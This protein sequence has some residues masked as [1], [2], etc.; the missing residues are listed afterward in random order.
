MIDWSSRLRLH[1][2]IYAIFTPMNGRV[3]TTVN[4]LNP[5]LFYAEG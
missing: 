1:L 2:K 5:I 4:V 3:L